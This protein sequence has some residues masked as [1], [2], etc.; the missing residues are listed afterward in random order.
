MSDSKKQPMN[1]TE[2]YTKFML[3][4]LIQHNGVS[5][6]SGFKTTTLQKVLNCMIE[7]F[8]NL[9]S[10]LDVPKISNKISEVKA[11]LSIFL[12]LIGISNNPNTSG[13]GFDAETQLVTAPAAVWDEY[14][15]AHPKAKK[16]PLCYLAE[17]GAFGTVVPRQACQR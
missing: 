11:D 8:K 3:E 12:D 1:W 7:K 2:A 6:N 10:I 17:Q 13:W 16:N 9:S 14:L 4:L 15:K 5:S